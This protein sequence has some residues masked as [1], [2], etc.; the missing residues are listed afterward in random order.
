MNNC[1]KLFDIKELINWHLRQYDSPHLAC[2]IADG[3]SES[4]LCLIHYSV[5]PGYDAAALVNL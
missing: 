3:M 2:I 5:F 4:S 1:C